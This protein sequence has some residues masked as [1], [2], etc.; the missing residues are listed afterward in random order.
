MSRV[1]PLGTS[2]GRSVAALDSTSLCVLTL[3]RRVLQGHLIYTAATSGIFR[4]S[5]DHI[6]T[7]THQICNS[8]TASRSTRLIG[9]EPTR[10]QS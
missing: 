7:K 1:E 8:A 9:R 2:P 5:S 10:N 3:D 4:Q 6:E